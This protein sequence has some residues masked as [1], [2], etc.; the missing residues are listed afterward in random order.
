MSTST[1]PNVVILGEKGCE[2]M[3]IIRFR[4]NAGIQNFVLI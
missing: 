2:K 1:Q 3:R 4:E